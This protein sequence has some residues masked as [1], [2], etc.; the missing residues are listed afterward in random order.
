M[1]QYQYLFN[2]NLF[3][4]NF[5]Y[6]KYIFLIRLCYKS[7]II[8]VY[9]EPVRSSVA[10]GSASLLPYPRG[11]LLLVAQRTLQPCFVATVPS[12]IA[13]VIKLV[14]CSLASSFARYCKTAVFAQEGVRDLWLECCQHIHGFLVHS[15]V[16]T[17]NEWN[18]PI[19]AIHASVFDNLALE[20][21]A[22]ICFDSE[23]E[24]RYQMIAFLNCRKHIWQYKL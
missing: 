9:S 24:S 10:L 22:C 4:Y 11:A 6:K 18:L 2:Q 1:V 7:S 16:V 5:T 3:T 19:I 15:A 12:C 20:H 23:R 21:V 13:L 17:K 14:Q 8:D